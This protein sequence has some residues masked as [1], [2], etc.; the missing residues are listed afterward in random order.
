MIEF[1]VNDTPA[2]TASDPRTPLLAVLR[3]E[4]CLTGAKF[5]CDDGRCGEG[6]CRSAS[7]P[8]LVDDVDDRAAAGDAQRNEE[9]H[10]IAIGNEEGRHRHRIDGNERTPD[11]EGCSSA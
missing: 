1:I 11:Q 2:R 5:G 8:E 7:R 6:E 9:R 3:D 4:L 10:S